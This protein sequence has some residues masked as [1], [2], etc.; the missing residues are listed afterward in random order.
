MIKNSVTFEFDKNKYYYDKD[1]A[2]RP[3]KFIERFC[4]HTA[5]ELMGE[6]IVLFDWQK[7][8]IR[9]A[10][11][12]LKKSNGKRKYRFIYL[13]VPKKNG[14]SMI[15]SGISLYL[16]MADGEKGAEVFA[17]AGDREQ[18]RIVFGAAKLMVEQE[19][20]LSERLEVLKN[21]ITYHKSGSVFKVVSSE[22]KTK[23]GPN[24]HGIVF[25]ELHVQ[26]HSDLY[27]TLTK[28]IASR[29][30]P[31]VWMITTAGVKETWAETQHDYAVGI[32]DGKYT[33]EKW[34]VKIYAAKR[35]EED[36]L[37][38][39]R[40]EVWADSNPS[41]PISP[42]RE[43]FEG[44]I[45]TIR[46]KPANLNAFLRL[47]LNI[48]TGSSYAWMPDHKWIK[49]NLGHVDLNNLLGQTCY[50]G[51]DL[52]AKSDF[53]SFTLLFP[54]NEHFDFFT[55]LVKFWCPQERILERDKKE[56][57]N[58]GQW[59][60]QG[61]ID[62]CPGD[63]MENEYPEK[64]IED[65]FDKYVIESIGYDRYRAVDLVIRLTNRGVPMVPFAQGPV[66][67]NAA[68]ET[69]EE[70]ILKQ[71]LNHLGNPVL[72]WQSGNMMIREDV[73]KNKAPDKRKSKDK[74]DGMV[75]LLNAIL[76]YL[77]FLKEGHQDSVYNER[78][79]LTIKFND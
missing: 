2:E 65:C 27:D 28:G 52:G 73:N 59:V 71:S 68:I 51:L 14:K 74:I 33:D 39:E 40:E 9:E 50:G 26:P 58:F 66:T 63:I 42:D 67:M 53:S 34:L 13:E 64:Y 75:S 5:G 11:G 37:F 15:L 18:A 20:W 76:C 3:I 31:M 36:P 10:F 46:N 54:P 47:H 62:T 21:T 8:L 38:Y 24:L 70:W 4:R 61:L 17:C 30:Q 48:W 69:L 45:E 16:T 57:A 56:H 77:V 19:K 78:G 60:R 35:D 79:L 43:Y 23:H 41:Y 44:E 6:L 55:C 22:S 32:R 49:S 7:N 29:K 12:V 1:A 72:R 25:D